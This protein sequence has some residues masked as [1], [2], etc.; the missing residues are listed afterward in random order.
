LLAALSSTLA[1]ASALQQGRLVQAA[2]AA[3]MVQ[4]LA[5]LKK[6]LQLGPAPKLL[7][8][9]GLL[10]VLV[11]AGAGTRAVVLRVMV[12]RMLSWLLR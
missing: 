9:L 3:L 2:V 12:Q 10:L 5:G 8:T 11:A 6:Q 1:A 7:G 4:A